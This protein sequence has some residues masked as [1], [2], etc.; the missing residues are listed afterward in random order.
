MRRPQLTQWAA[1]LEGRIPS[2]TEWATKMVSG[3]AGIRDNR[4]RAP[5][6]QSTDSN[7]TANSLPAAPAHGNENSEQDDREK[8]TQPQHPGPS[9]PNTG[10]GAGQ[11][12]S[13][14]ALQTMVE[15]HSQILAQ[16]STQETQL[17]EVIRLSK[18]EAETQRAQATAATA[19]LKRVTLANEALTKDIAA[20]LSAAR[21][22]TRAAQDATAASQAALRR[23]ADKSEAE[24]AAVEAAHRTQ[25]SAATR[26]STLDRG[27]FGQ[28]AEDD[29]VDVRRMYSAPTPELWGD[30]VVDPTA[31]P[32]HYERAYAVAGMPDPLCRGYKPRSAPRGVMSMHD[33]M[34]T[35][36]DFMIDNPV[37][38]A[39]IADTLAE[40][41]PRITVI[42]FPERV[43]KRQRVL[44]AQ[45]VKGAHTHCST[46]P[47]TTHKLA[48][49][50]YASYLVEYVTDEPQGQM[51][52]SQ[53]SVI[54]DIDGVSWPTILN[55]HTQSVYLPVLLIVN[56][57]TTRGSGGKG[58]RDRSTSEE[59]DVDQDRNR[60][61]R[62]NTDDNGRS[63]RHRAD[64]YRQYR[65]DRSGDECHKR[66]RG[67]DADLYRPDRRSTNGS[68]RDHRHR[69]NERGGGHRDRDGRRDSDGDRDHD[70]R[71]QHSRHHGNSDDSDSDESE[72][73]DRSRRDR[74]RTHSPT[75][76]SGRKRKQ[77][78]DN[79][80][81][82]TEGHSRSITDPAGNIVIHSSGKITA[83]MRTTQAFRAITNETTRD[84]LCAAQGNELQNY[85]P[86][87]LCAG[88][89]NKHIKA[90]STNTSDP[91]LH[92]LPDFMQQNW[93]TQGI[94]HPAPLAT[95]AI[96]WDVNLAARWQP[97]SLRLCHFQRTVNL[98]G[99]VRTHA[100]WAEAIEGL[101]HHTNAF[102]GGG[103]LSMWQSI[104]NVIARDQ[105]GRNYTYGYL[106]STT[107]D[108]LYR[109][110]DAA[111]NPL[112]PKRIPG[113]TQLRIPADLTPIQWVAA[114]AEGFHALFKRYQDLTWF[115]QYEFGHRN[116]LP[117]PQ[118]KG[119][120]KDTNKRETP[121][122]PT[123][124]ARQ[125]ADNN[126]P[127]ENAGKGNP[128]GKPKTL[129]SNDILC[130]YKMTEKDGKKSKPC[131]EG[132]ERTHVR[133]Y[134]KN[135]SRSEV[136]HAVSKY[137]SRKLTLADYGTLKN[138]V[139]KD[140]KYK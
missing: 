55:W 127:G 72:S 18:E 2:R 115:H 86:R 10:L 107:N 103:W 69:D 40:L 26:A 137:C 50:A 4:S 38:A 54:N 51:I 11:G 119:V 64:D 60:D 102:F 99:S 131:K 118:A 39:D 87:L 15:K 124:L 120:G 27:V 92:N 88:A 132:C 135:Q 47:L 65:D 112:V 30:L 58:R 73:S 42:K 17:R 93:Y 29:D 14:S 53:P 24:A 106:E 125:T 136:L 49:C 96:M 52:L 62:S 82:E 44:V 7:G 16:W 98:T 56:P 8:R 134:P 71:H 3:E 63:K 140:V 84:Q 117:P 116:A 78:K 34:R 129:C 43:H 128:K 9:N 95:K 104:T 22:A 57:A 75:P 28:L 91:D 138:L 37:P 67:N 21:A 46:P 89:I 133:N 114:V 33:T 77:T 70:H 35:K 5:P 85:N 111:R 139:A 100:D 45:T 94:N 61:D 130:H 108:V 121:G 110:G 20:Q 105:I 25:L 80:E 1:Q 68:G 109:I 113:H 12:T 36:G 101:G 126:P 31:P 76:V 13:G 81:E 41:L 122:K 48:K 32:P 59:H 6:D 83:L 74:R 66:P 19:E 79:Q 123:P 90:T 97:D 23:Q